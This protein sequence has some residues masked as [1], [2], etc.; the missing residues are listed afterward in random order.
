MISLVFRG[1]SQAYRNSRAKS[2]FLVPMERGA[3]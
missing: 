3:R 2:W 1:L